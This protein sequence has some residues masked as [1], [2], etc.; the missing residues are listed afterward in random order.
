MIRTWKGLSITKQFGLNFQHFVYLSFP[1][2]SFWSPFGT[3]GWH[4]CHWGHCGKKRVG[5]WVEFSKLRWLIGSFCQANRGSRSALTSGLGFQAQ[6]HTYVS[7][8]EHCVW[9]STLHPP[10]SNCLF[11]LLL[12]PKFNN[13][14]WKS[15]D[16]EIVLWSQDTKSHENS[17]EPSLCPC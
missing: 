7:F 5:S 3:H 8:L 9:Y 16:R 6:S 14:N 4:K 13:H 15:V 2:P 17:W 10:I 12:E 11:L 1:Y